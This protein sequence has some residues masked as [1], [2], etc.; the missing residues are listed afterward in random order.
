MNI[1]AIV[2]AAIVIFAAVIGIRMLTQAVSNSRS[3]VVESDGHGV[4]AGPGKEAAQVVH[5]LANAGV[6]AW[7]EEDAASGETKVFVEDEQKDQVQALLTVQQH[8]EQE[9][10]Q[11][12]AVTEQPA[13]TVVTATASA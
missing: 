9:Q 12:A 3:V 7:I 2:V 11:A 8:M 1:F 10:Q 4:F 6:I 5:T 13:E